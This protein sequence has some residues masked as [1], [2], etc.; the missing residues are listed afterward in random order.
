MKYLRVGQVFFCMVAAVFGL[1]T[2]FPDASILD[3]FWGWFLLNCGVQ[4]NPVFAFLANTE[5]GIS[6]LVRR[7]LLASHLVLGHSTYTHP[8]HLG[9]TIARLLRKHDDVHSNAPICWGALFQSELERS[10]HSIVYWYY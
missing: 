4:R 9:L 5:L 3:Y 7:S 10:N 6:R 1:L 2:I 8:V